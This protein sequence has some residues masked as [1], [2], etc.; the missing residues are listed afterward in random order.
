MLDKVE[1]V[2]TKQEANQAIAEANT[3]LDNSIKAY[4]ASILAELGEYDLGSLA[5][6][7][8]VNERI[9]QVVGAAPEA[10]DTLEDIAARLA[11]DSDA[12]T[13]INGV[14]A[15]KAVKSEVEAAISALTARVT[16][17]ETALASRPAVPEADNKLYGI[18]NGAYTAIT[19]QGEKILTT[20]AES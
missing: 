17:L 14:L 13:A 15:G 16:A 4:Y 5:P 20:H 10:L 12:V 18:K 6:K 7:S 1:N 8:Y 19:T 2:Y 3:M 9:Q 11:S